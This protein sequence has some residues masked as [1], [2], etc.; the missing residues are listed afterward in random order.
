MAKK[1]QATV[2]VKTGW[3]NRGRRYDEACEQ[4]GKIGEVD[5]D[6]GLCRSCGEEPSRA[7]IEARLIQLENIR[8]AYQEPGD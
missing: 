3:A 7:I 8:T 6:T 4:C 2:P 5:N 1:K